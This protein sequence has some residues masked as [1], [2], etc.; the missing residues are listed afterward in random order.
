MFSFVD[1]HL[2]FRVKSKKRKIEQLNLYQFLSQR[3]GIGSKLSTLI[4][5]HVGYAKEF[6]STL[7]SANHMTDKIRKFFVRNVSMLD[8]NLKEYM[9]KRIDHYIKIGCYRGVRHVFNYPCRGQ[10]TRSNASTR[11]SM[12]FKLHIQ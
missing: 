3:Y 10:R 6:P 4:L 8:H 1:S 12:R 11:K 7:V 9:L 2:S 5:S